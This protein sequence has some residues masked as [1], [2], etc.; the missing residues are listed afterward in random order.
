LSTYRLELDAGA[1]LTIGG[2]LTTY[3]HLI[4]NNT[5]TSP[6][7]LLVSGSVTG[8]ATVN[9]ID[10]EAKRWWYMGHIVDYNDISLTDDYDSSVGASTTYYLQQYSNSSGWGNATSFTN[11]LD[12][13]AFAVL[14]ASTLS[15]DGELN[16]S[17]S[18][19]KSDMTAGW[20]VISN[21]FPAYLDVTDESNDFGSFTKS[22]YI[23]TDLLSD[24]SR[25]YSTVNFA[26]DVETVN[27]GSK[28]I[29][30]GQSFLIKLEGELSSSITLSKDAC[31]HQDDVVLKGSSKENDKI[32]LYLTNVNTNCE[33]LISF[34]EEGSES[35][36]AY[37][38][39]KKMTSG[40]VANLYSIKDDKDLVINSLPELDTE[41]IIPLGYKVSESGMT[42]F[43][44]E[45]DLTDLDE[46]YA[47][48]LVD[49]DEDVIVNLREESSYTFTPSETQ[50][51]DRFEIRLESEAVTTAIDEEEMQISDDDVFIYSVK[52]TATVQVSQELLLGDNRA[53]EIYNLAGQL[54]SQYE[55]NEIETKVNLPQ[56]NTV[57]IIR[58]K[59]DTASYQ[60]KV[61][62]MR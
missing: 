36:T 50:S 22:I 3:G 28:Y 58:V 39:E 55:L 21:P 19:T 34:K 24:G 62:G 52:Q 35:Y 61:V 11:Q 60:E 38:S 9:W 25:Q 40:L 7:S 4:I 49:L 48:Y 17:T 41:E 43:T 8:E 13:Y 2:N 44:I 56:T 59:I 1:Q 54:I 15:Y 12:G 57:Y 5:S 47:V 6:A 45:A 18:Y 53:I 29:A 16:D 31:S 46:Y 27:E 32:R 26:G 37:D 33:T 23:W 20:Y 51:D 30:P 42:D 14:E 10:L